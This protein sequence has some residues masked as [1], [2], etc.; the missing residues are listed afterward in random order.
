MVGVLVVGVAYPIMKTR[1]KLREVRCKSG[2]RSRFSRS[3]ILPGDTL[4]GEE[5]SDAETD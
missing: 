5:N 1:R 3:H 4:R 2:R